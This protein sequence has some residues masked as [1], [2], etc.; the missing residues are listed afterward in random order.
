MFV[1][2]PEHIRSTIAGVIDESANDRPICLAVAFWGDGAETIVPAGKRYRIICNL[3]TGG[4]NPSTI[5]KLMMYPNTEVKNRPSLHAKVVIGQN[6]CFL[7]SANFSDSAIGFHGPATW[8][9]ANLLLTKLDERFMDIQQW[10]WNQWTDSV[11]ISES[12]L[13]N[14]E[15]KWALRTRF[16]TDL[17]ATSNV[18]SNALASRY[19]LREED[20]FKPAITGGNQIRMASSAVEALFRKLKPNVDKTMIRV[21]AFVSAILWT[22]SGRSISTAIQNRQQFQIPAHVWERALESGQPKYNEAEIQ[23]FLSLLSTDAEAPLAIRFWAKQY[24][25]AGCPG[26][27]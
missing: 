8:Q 23:R 21:P 18:E 12:D 3:S 14:A 2:S 7:G 9:E 5:R 1:A 16:L 13:R 27:P 4:T 10:F 15:I 26:A 17:R 24:I 19:A 20:L 22:Y 11:L 25:E 6:S